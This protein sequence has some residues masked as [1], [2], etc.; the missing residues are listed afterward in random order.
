M[1]TAGAR[2]GRWTWAGLAAVGALACGGASAQVLLKEPP[3]DLQGVQVTE[4]RGSQLP[5]DLPLIDSDGMAV[6]L[7]D[8]FD[9]KRPVALL[10]AYYSCPML[11]NLNLAGV[12]ES[13]RDLRWELGKDYR[14]V[15]LSF[16]HRNSV[17]EAATKKAIFTKLLRE[18]QKK[19]WAFLLA[20]EQNARLAADAAGFA[21]RF[22]PDS[23]EYAHDWA[24]IV[25]TP[26]GE[27]STYLYGKYGAAYSEKQ[28]RLALA[29]AADG[30]M[31]SVF[32]RITLWCYHYDPTRGAYTVQAFRVMQIGGAVTALALGTF[33]GGMFFAGRR[34]RARS[35]PDA[36][37]SL[38]P[39]HAG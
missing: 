18:D 7:G 3:K 16:D 8:Y 29:D 34:R 28:M 6:R 20:T 32:D 13:V 38:S 27:V 39:S 23:G 15:T 21:Y 31:G 14:L 26:S 24:V 11:C 35:A 17:D 12:Q 4:K 9:G 30:K 2:S 19:D 36:S 33:V 5:L 37:G 25:C 1:R 10:F 22:L